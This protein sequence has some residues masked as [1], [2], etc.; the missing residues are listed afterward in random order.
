[1]LSGTGT[2]L[3]DHLIE[4]TA[5]V[6]ARRGAGG[7]TVRGI[8]KEAGVA[9]GVLYNHFADREELL[10]LALR[11]YVRSVMAS[12]GD[13][14]ARPG[15]RTVEENLTGFMTQAIALHVAILPVFAGLL[16]EPKV[17]AR[18]FDQPGTPAGGLGLR[19]RLA[20]YLR[21]ERRLGRIAAEAD[22]DSPATMLIGACHELV[23]PHLY[24]GAGPG[25]I[26]VPDGF[27][28]DLVATVLRGIGPRT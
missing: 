28:D 16:G 1:M 3:R 2:S 4:S 26:T 21:A 9:A 19:D 15:E 12:L 22:T 27:V 8:A 7:L 24:T 14:P 6:I 11:S 10:A 20:D 23:L 25:R 17:L 13:S 5:Q 18:F